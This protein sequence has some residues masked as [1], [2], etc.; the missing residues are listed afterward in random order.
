MK[1]PFS[2]LTL[3][4]VVFMAFLYAPVILLPIFSVN[5]NTFA[6]FPLKGFTWKHYE[7][8]AA[9]TSMLEALV[10][11][12]MV[13]VTAAVVATALGLVASIVLT[14]RLLPGTGVLLATIMLPLIVPSIIFAVAFLVLLVKV[15]RIDLSLWT[16]TIAHIFVCLPFSVMVLMAR[17]EG[18][19]R[20]LEEASG[21]LGE[22]AWG[23][24]RRVTLPLVMPAVISSLLMCFVT[25]FDE[26][27]M[28]FFLSGTKPTLP[29]FL[30]G[31]LRFPAKLPQ[32]LAL[33][34]LIL[35]ASTVLAVA[36]EVIRRRGVAPVGA[37]DV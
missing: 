34:S 27:V 13:G 8:M 5:D 3:Y 30:Y 10:N 15:L 20:S 1:K 16:I 23:T 22:S 19:D 4:A 37:T 2:S 26:F 11:S 24:F 17:F 25:S 14:R 28:A 12:L 21:D 6:V 31:Q 7:S 9:N 18:L 32:V 29:V 36:A 35:V 33:G